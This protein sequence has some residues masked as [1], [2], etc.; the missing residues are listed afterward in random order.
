VTDQPPIYRPTAHRWWLLDELLS[1]DET[2]APLPLAELV[3]PLMSGT[4]P[5]APLIDAPGPAWS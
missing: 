2:L 3:A 1:T 4:E 5:P